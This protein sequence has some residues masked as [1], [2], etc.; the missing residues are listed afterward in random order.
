MYI[1]FLFILTIF[2]ACK[3][4]YKIQDIGS[5]RNKENIIFGERNNQKWDCGLNIAS[6]GQVFGLIAFKFDK[7]S[8]L[9]EEIQISRIQIKTGKQKLENEIFNYNKIFAA[10]TKGYDDEFNTF[11]LDTTKT[12]TIDF[13]AINLQDGIITGN[14]D[15]TFLY[16]NVDQSIDS[17]QFKNLK[18]EY[19]R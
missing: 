13:T 15:A 2:T 12:N 14:L 16:N 1:R 4:E 6:N 5:W 17:V 8:V 3:K 11:Y 18:F 10:Y 9:I 19:K 7:D